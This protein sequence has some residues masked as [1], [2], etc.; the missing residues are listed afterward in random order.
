M[1]EKNIS[2]HK[3]IPAIQK[4]NFHLGS[5]QKCHSLIF[6]SCSHLIS[7]SIYAFLSK[8]VIHKRNS[9]SP[10]HMWILKIVVWILK[11]LKKCVLIIIYLFL[12]LN[13]LLLFAHKVGKKKKKREVNLWFTRPN[14]ICD[15]EETQEAKPNWNVRP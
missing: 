2:K 3:L 14:S 13:S 7:F 8:L 1:K 5:K 12:Y 9:R 11:D 15:P 6:E 10:Y 4:L